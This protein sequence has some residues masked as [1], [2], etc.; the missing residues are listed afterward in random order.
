MTRNS[1]RLWV[2][3]AAATALLGLAACGASSPEP[4]GSGGARQTIVFAESG[5]GAEEQQTQQAVDG[6]ERAHP[7]IHV[8][9]DV[10]SPNSTRYLSQLEHSFTAGSATPD[11][12]ESD[13]TYPP[14]FARAGWAL[15]L[16]R[17]SPDM[18]R[19]LAREAAFGTHKGGVYAIPWFDDPEG[20]YYRTDLIK[21][22]PASPAQV[23]A[24]A[25]AAMKRDSSITA[26]LAFEGAEYEGAITAFQT[27]ES[28]FGGKLETSDIDTAGNVAALAW[29]QDAIYQNHIAPAGVTGWHE[30]QVAREFVSG[31]AAFAID[32]PFVEEMAARSPVRGKVG[33]IPFPAGPGGTPGSALGGEMLAINARSAHAAAAWQL[34]QYLTSQKVEITRAEATGDP[35]SLAGAYTQALYAKAPYLKNVRTLGSYAQP[36]P[37]NPDYLTVS[38]DLQ[39][40]LAQVFAHATSPTKALSGAAPAIRK[41]GNINTPP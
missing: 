36:R 23:V 35:P 4:S 31:H 32:Y 24:D 2:S 8:K 5:L 41:D 21:T 38:R 3:A 13:V 12:F 9:L 15:D 33:Y 26:G 16:R 37:V 6:F 27:V 11:V 18:K 39:V 29:L 25:K 22:P 1:G 28:A 10:L 30:S 17:F 14:K 19:Y 20:L 34:I 40:M 7:D